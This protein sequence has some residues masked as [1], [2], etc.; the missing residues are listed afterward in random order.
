MTGKYGMIIAIAIAS[1]G[2]AVA[3]TLTRAVIASSGPTRPEVTDAL[4]QSR[5]DPASTGF[6]AGRNPV[7]VPRN[8]PVP[9][10]ADPASAFRTPAPTERV[11]NGIYGVTGGI[12]L[13]VCNL[14]ELNGERANDCN[15]KP[16]HDLVTPPPRKPTI[17]R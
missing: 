4:G 17:N 8:L 9:A 5:R 1:Q 6:G 2:C 3:G 16:R 15:I 11:A 10:S 7:T 13:F 12:V 14:P